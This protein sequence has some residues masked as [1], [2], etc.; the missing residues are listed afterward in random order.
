MSAV[1][2]QPVSR[3]ELHYLGQLRRRIGV[4]L[5]KLENDSAFTNSTQIEQAAVHGSPRTPHQRGGILDIS[6]NDFK[7]LVSVGVISPSVRVP[8]SRGAYYTGLLFV[9]LEH[10]AGAY[11]G[12]T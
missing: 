7:F 11:G 8:H 12:N 3:H 2:S 6:A 5:S 10:F 1:N 4:N 9:E